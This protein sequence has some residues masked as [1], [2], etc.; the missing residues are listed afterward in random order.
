ML[1]ASRPLGLM[2]GYEGEDGILTGA[3]GAVYRTGDVAF[4]DD[5][6]YLTF[7]G[8]SDDVFKS[9]DYRISPFELESV[10]IE[11]SVRDRGGGKCLRPDAV[12]L[13][14]PKAYVILAAGAEPDRETARSIF[15]L[16]VERLAPFKRIRPHRIRR[17][18]AEDDLGQDSQGRTAP[19]RA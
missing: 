18:A 16:T 2:Q 13:S 6:G 1:G 11:P 3:E 19:P 8:R 7:V 12:K 5:D 17:I 15:R 14:V 9:S 4:R 10:L